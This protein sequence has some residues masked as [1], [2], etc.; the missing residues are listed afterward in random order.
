MLL[1]SPITVLNAFL[2]LKSGLIPSIERSLEVDEGTHLRYI[3]SCGLLIT[4]DRQRYLLLP[5]LL[6]TGVTGIASAYSNGDTQN[7]LSATI[8][9]QGQLGQ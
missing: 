7:S 5:P 9:L 4:V 8:G 6:A 3:T 2:I 1:D